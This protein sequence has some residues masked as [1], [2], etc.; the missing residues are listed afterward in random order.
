MVVTEIT[1]EVMDKI[2]SLVTI[3]QAIGGFI[4]LYVIFNSISIWHNWNKT[5]DT[6][7]MRET[8][9]RIEKKLDGKKLVKR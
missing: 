4:V 7:R 5:K 6:A 3:L 2:S 1:A 8:L 9:E